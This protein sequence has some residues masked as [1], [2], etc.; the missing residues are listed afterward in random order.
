MN[1]E[2]SIGHWI[3]RRRK[4]L[5]LTQQQL[6]ERVGCATATIVKIEADERRPSREIA[7]L[8][9]ERLEIPLEERAEFLRVARRERH[10]AALVSPDISA[11][12]G[13]PPI[14]SSPTSRLPVPLTP[15]IGRE[16]ELAAIHQM[17][18]DPH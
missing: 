6:A 3:R 1:S 11:A 9:A 16:R 12:T 5:D 2:V 17:L 10:V 7:Q 8:L 4:S 13:R 15:L 14:S 18:H